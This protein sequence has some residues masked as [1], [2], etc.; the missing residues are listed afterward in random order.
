[1][2]LVSFFR[3]TCTIFESRLIPAFVELIIDELLP[4]IVGISAVRFPISRL[5][6]LVAVRFSKDDVEML[7]SLLFFPLSD[8]IARVDCPVPVELSA[9]VLDSVVLTDDLNSAVVVSRTTF[10]VATLAEEFLSVPNSRFAQDVTLD[11]VLTSKAG[12]VWKKD[13]ALSVIVIVELLTERFSAVLLSR[14]VAF[15]SSIKVAL[16]EARSF[17]SNDVL[18]D[19]LLTL[20]DVKLTRDTFDANRSRNRLELE[21]WPPFFICCVKLRKVVDGVTSTVWLA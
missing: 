18:F 9:E 16:T 11:V 10:F 14:S 15:F 13:E 7:K 8:V 6:M 17:L 21:R 2:L 5:R 12:R 19:A 20:D 1:M 4:F 3:G